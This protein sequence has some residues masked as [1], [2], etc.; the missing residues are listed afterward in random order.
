MHDTWLWLKH[1]A[2][3]GQEAAA[4]TGLLDL[5]LDPEKERAV[6]AAVA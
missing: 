4:G 6:L 2:T 1:D 3:A 5:G